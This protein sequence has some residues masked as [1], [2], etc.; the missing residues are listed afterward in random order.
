M[1]V[2]HSRRPAEAIQPGGKPLRRE[3][4]PLPLT[5]NAKFIS[6]FVPFCHIKL[7]RGEVNCFRGIE[8]IAITGRKKSNWSCDTSA[9]LICAKR[10]GLITGFG[11]Q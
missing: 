5:H 7:H 6:N 2:S 1:S 8:I 4:P 10:G 11:F 9:S 3:L